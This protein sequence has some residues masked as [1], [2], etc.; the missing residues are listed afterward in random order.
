MDGPSPTLPTLVLWRTD[1]CGLC[2][3]T[4]HLL[5]LLLAERAAAGLAVPA[6]VERDLAENPEAQ[7]ALSELIPVLELAGRRLELALH[8]GP[9]RAFLAEAL[10]VPGPPR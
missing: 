3:E 5:R 8:P 7:R 2:N 4:R 10:D 9:I 6:I 1:G